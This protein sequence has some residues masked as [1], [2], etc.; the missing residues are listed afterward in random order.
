MISWIANLLQKR[1]KI[2][3]SVLLAIIIVA[4]VFTIGAGPGIVPDERSNF[5]RDF[6]GIDLNSS[7]Q[8]Q[9]LQSATMV[10]R[11]LDGI[12]QFDDSQFQEQ[13]LTRQVRLHL[14]DQ[15]SIPNPTESQ[16]ADFLKSKRAFQNASGRFEKAL[17]ENFVST[18]QSDAL[19]N[20]SFVMAVLKEDFRLEQLDTLMTQPGFLFEEEV[21]ASLAREQTTWSVEVAKLDYTTFSPVLEIDDAAIEAY[22]AEQQ[23]TYRIPE[24]FTL[25]FVEFGADQVSGP[26]AD[27]GDEELQRYFLTQRSKFA[28][29]EEA[30]TPEGEDAVAPA[31]LEIFAQI[32]GQVFNTWAAER[33]TALAEEVANE[34][35]SKLFEENI[36]YQSVEFKKMLLDHSIRLKDLPPFTEA[37]STQLIGVVPA[38]LYDAA[39]RLGG[40]RYF[41]DV[42]ANRD[43]S[44]F[45][46]GFLESRA[47]ARIPQLSEVRAQVEAD[48]RESQ[49]QEAFAAKGQA[50]ADTISQ[51]DN[52]LAAIAQAEGLALETYE[53][54]T[55]ADRPEG[56]SFQ[57]LQAMEP[58][59]QGEV[60]DMITV[61]D[62]GYFLKITARNTPEVTAEDARYA[63]IS[64]SLEGFSGFARYQAIMDQLLSLKLGQPAQ[65]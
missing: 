6:Y 13:M 33:R 56:L 46:V 4:F 8:V 52:N 54:F 44:K 43:R 32:R 19:I 18:L 61:G 22:F 2:I 64:S 57:L 12:R 59:K 15:L 24:E 1:G 26:V 21:L 30:L 42:I 62:A 58:L 25:Q 29:A 3:F 53:S 36:P 65:N 7:G 40:N 14:A 55:F 47:P 34:F 17:L 41:T 16:L 37:A 10:S 28:E 45:L 27:P 5:Q 39:M 23:L 60:S 20:D 48:Y 35:I 63:A 11:Y 49:K 50:I 31:P 9:Q 38:E 51:S